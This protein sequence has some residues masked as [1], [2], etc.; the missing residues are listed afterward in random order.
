MDT[1]TTNNNIPGKKG[2]IARLIVLGITVLIG[3]LFSF[4]SIPDMIPKRGLFPAI[5]EAIGGS[6][7][8][9]LL[10]AFFWGAMK[11]LGF[12]APKSFHIANS[13][14]QLWTPLT[15]LG[16]YVKVCI[17]LIITVV[18][19]E[20]YFFLLMPLASLSGHFAQ[21]NI[22]FFSA[23][24]LFLGGAALVTAI[25]FLDICKLRC[26]SPI[27]TIKEVLAAKK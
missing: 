11:W 12:I 22:D 25:G 26:V 5:W 19:C 10:A 14:W 23:I 20:I 13:F 21:V 1:Y 24:G 27:D 2:A 4:G 9:F 3:L 7:T 6:G 17:W 16:V 18:P 8:I 15:F